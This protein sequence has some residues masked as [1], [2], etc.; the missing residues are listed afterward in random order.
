MKSDRR[1]VVVTGMGIVTP[2]GM[3]LEGLWNALDAGT[4][5]MRPIRSFPTGGIPL[6]FAAEAADFTGDI[7]DFG[8]LEPEQKK[9]I[10]K[11]LKVMCRES[12]MAVAAAQRAIAH[13][14]VLA[15]AEPMARERIGCVFGSDYMMTLPEDFTASVAAC[16]GE[17]GGFEFARWAEQGLPLLNPLWLLKYLPNMPASHIAIYNDLRGPSNSLTLREASGH[18][19]VGEAVMTIQRGA[20]DVMLAGATGTRVHPMKTV[21]SLQNEQVALDDATAGEPAT[22]HRPFDRGRRGMTLGEGAAVLVL[23]EMDRAIGRSA[24]IHGEIVGHG[25]ATA[26][27][28]RATGRLDVALAGAMRGAIASSGLPAE[29][30]GHIHAHGLGTVS[31]DRDEAAAMRSVFG[32][33]VTTIPTVAAKG[34]F[35]NLGAASGLVEAVSSMLA[36]ANGSLFPMMNHQSPDPECMIR[37]ARRGDPA[38]EN[39]LASS[40]TPQGQASAIVVRRMLATA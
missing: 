12:Q 14:G 11:G 9:A 10:R 29:Q 40:V 22:W 21:H 39:F 20:A 32:D 19:A 1:R 27:D 33:S 34:H 18:L 7:A 4:S 31:C 13:S 25:A 2:L 28:A 35:G 6:S 24:M 8:S 15:S 23:E 37:A 17:S 36:L 26:C 30:I 5:G 38:G 3:T 16:R